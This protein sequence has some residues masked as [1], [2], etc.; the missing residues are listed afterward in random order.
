MS[1]SSKR[2]RVVAGP[3]VPRTTA[4]P[5]FG[6][7][8][9]PLTTIRGAGIAR[10]V[11]T[12]GVCITALGATPTAWETCGI[13]P[14]SFRALALARL[15]EEKPQNLRGLSGGPWFP[16]NGPACQAWPQQPS[17]LTKMRPAPHRFQSN[18]FSS[19]KSPLVSPSK[20][21]PS[22]RR[23]DFHARCLLPT[24]RC[25]LSYYPVFPLLY[26]LPLCYNHPAVEH[27][28]KWGLARAQ[29]EP[30]QAAV[31]SAVSL[32]HGQS[33]AAPSED[34]S[35]YC[36]VCSQRLQ[37]RRCK[38]ICSVCGYYMSCADYY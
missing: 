9:P 4:V 13:I 1:S 34:P 23:I 6:R 27:A 21:P 25:P 29:A 24:T 30:A 19:H 22:S 36:P 5:V 18:S 32:Q 8:P 2:L 16:P 12:R 37:S 17:P 3:R 15:Q 26:S 35:R 28:A 14:R 31:Q 38:L 20:N 33:A 10:A 11:P 7:T